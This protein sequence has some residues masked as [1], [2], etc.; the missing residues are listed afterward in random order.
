MSGHSK[1]SSIK[2]KKAVIDAKKGKLFS[3]LIREISIAARLGGS[4]LEGNAR[5]RLAVQKAKDCNMPSDNI[6]RAIQKGSGELCEGA[7]F[8]EVIYEGYGPGGIAILIEAM[9]DNKNRTTANIR[10]IFSKRG[11]SLGESGC[12]S[13]MFSKKGY[14]TINKSK[15]TEEDLLDIVT[16]AEAEDY[17]VEAEVYEIYT[18]PSKLEAVRKALEDKGIKIETADLTMIPQSSISVDKKTAEQLL[19]LIKYLE[20]DEDIQQVHANFDI[21]DE[22]L[23]EIEEI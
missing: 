11:G 4:D 17:K 9:T 18:E 14:L 20:D 16:K 2:H 13:W 23:K 1:W 10:S 19:K 8:E 22:I 15:I 3:K 5:L 7:S 6:K 12:V 21:S